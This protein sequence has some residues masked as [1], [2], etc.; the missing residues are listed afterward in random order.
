M[1]KSTWKHI[2]VITDHFVYAYDIFNLTIPIT[3]IVNVNDTI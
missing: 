1:T 2:E 3:I